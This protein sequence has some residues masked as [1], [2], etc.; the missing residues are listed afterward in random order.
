LLK[1][2]GCAAAYFA[3]AEDYLKSPLRCDTTF[4]ILDVHMP[5]MSG[6]MLQAQMVAEGDD[7][8][9]IFISGVADE[10][11]KKRAL[12]AGA[13]G[14][15]SKPVDQVSLMRLLDG[16]VTYLAKAERRH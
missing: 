13:R 4:L 12:E 14:F 5:G 10:E 1:S 7:T 3:S 9:I 15:L 11:T 8:P 2:L 16:G 6:L